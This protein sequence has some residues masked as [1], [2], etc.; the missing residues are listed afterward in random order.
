MNVNLRKSDKLI[1][2]VGVIILIVAGVGIALYVSEEPEEEIT[3]EPENNIYYPIFTAKSEEI[4]IK[5]Y[6]GKKYSDTITIDEVPSGCVLTGVDFCIKWKDDKTFGLIIKRGKDTLTAKISYME[7]TLTHSSKASGNET[8]SFDINSV[9]STDYIEAED[10]IEAE[11]M[12][13][14]MYSGMNEASFDI[15]VSVKTGEPF[16]RPLKFL[17]DKGNAFEIK[18]TYYY[19]DVDLEVEETDD[20][21]MDDF[22]E[23]EYV[24]EGGAVGEFYKNLCYGRSVI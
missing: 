13:Y 2:I 17:S 9:P 20:M 10:G 22:N 15:V 19:Y 16:Y 5:E 14:E 8:L 3:T 7:E 6:A 11:E 12:L 4:T 18:I 24:G 21:M 23:K 1:A